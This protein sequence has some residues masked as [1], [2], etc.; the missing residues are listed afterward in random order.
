MDQR[1]DV[2]VPER[3]DIR[4]VR[5]HRVRKGSM[6]GTYG[7]DAARH[8]DKD[9]ASHIH[10]TMRANYAPHTVALEPVASDPYP[11]RIP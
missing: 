2:T 8:S 1:P 3:V 6:Y 4:F 9:E 5:E 10:P 11:D 7:E